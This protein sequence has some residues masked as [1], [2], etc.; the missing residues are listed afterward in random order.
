MLRRASHYLGSG[1]G[2]HLRAVFIQGRIPHPVDPVFD[3][4]VAPPQVEQPGGAGLL[5]RQA[6]DS[7]GQLLRVSQN[8]PRLSRNLI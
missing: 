2:S 5:W 1:A 8:H 6:G 7:V 4:P 3:A